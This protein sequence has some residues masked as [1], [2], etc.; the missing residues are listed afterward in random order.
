MRGRALAD[1]H[2]IASPRARD[3]KSQRMH[4]ATALATDRAPCRGEG[5]R[6]CAARGTRASCTTRLTG[7]ASAPVGS[8]TGER[9]RHTHR[10]QSR[11]HG[12]PLGSSR[13]CASRTGGPTAARRLGTTR[14][15]VRRAAHP[16]RPLTLEQRGA[17]RVQH[18]RCQY[19]FR[20]GA[21][22]A[23]A[24]AVFL[25]HRVWARVAQTSLAPRPP[26]HECSTPSHHEPLG[27]PRPC[28]TTPC[29]ESV[30]PRETNAAIYSYYAR[31][32]P[33]IIERGSSIGVR[34]GRNSAEIPVVSGFFED[35][36]LG[37][38]KLRAL[39]PA[40]YTRACCC[41]RAPSSFA[42]AAALVKANVRAL[43]ARVCA[44]PT[45][46]S[47]RLTRS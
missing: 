16:T 25:L 15:L 26:L 37:P 33:V 32:T 39:G 28:H 34:S 35:F 20:G 43:R 7:T 10:A 44:E 30:A 13:C 1:A 40:Q 17:R 8:A 3:G 38:N 31:Y 47:K 6:P 18:G 11:C 19:F 2:T 27:H 23:T 21:C 24:R 41:P 45:R 22:A 5:S 42:L 29:R 46:L 9:R 14:A 4:S 36:E 12:L